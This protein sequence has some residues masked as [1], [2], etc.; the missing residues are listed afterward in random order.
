MS[1]APRYWTVC[2]SSAMNLSVVEVTVVHTSIYWH[3]WHEQL[4]LGKM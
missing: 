3:Y 2:F 1:A 4:L